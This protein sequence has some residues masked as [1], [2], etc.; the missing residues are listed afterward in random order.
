MKKA[1]SLALIFVLCLSLCACGAD[2]NMAGD[3]ESVG[4]DY[5]NDHLYRL[6]E[7]DTYEDV[8]P[9]SLVFGDSM[10]ELYGEDEAV[11][12]EIELYEKNRAKGTYKIVENGFTLTS[13]DGYDQTTFKKVQE[14]YYTCWSNRGLGSVI[15]DKDNEYGKVPTFSKDGKCSQTFEE[16]NMSKD[17]DCVFTLRE[18]GTFNRSEYDKKDYARE[19]ALTTFDG[20]YSLDGSVLTLTFSGQ[21]YIFLYANDNI[22][23]EVYKKVA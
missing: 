9:L 13:A 14:S 17:V 7:D 4:V 19:F 18:D 16:W 2:K 11:T 8:T 12:V 22:Y 10:L 6:N 20:T 15:F 23:T 3:Y 21:T 1:M 5:G